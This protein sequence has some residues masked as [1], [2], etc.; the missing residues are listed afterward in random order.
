MAEQIISPGVFTRENDLSFLP[1]GI[2]A[3]GAAIIGP[4]EKGPAFVPTVVRSF[5]EYERRFGPLSAETYVPQ[6][7]R[8]Y[9]KNAGSVTV[10]RVLAGGG[11]T[12]ANGTNE[13]VAI[14]LSGSS[15]NVFLGSIFP[16][17]HNTAV[18]DLSTSTFQNSGSHNIEMGVDEVT[19]TQNFV[20]QLKGATGGTQATVG[21]TYAASINPANYNYIF[22][23]LGDK[24]NNSKTAWNAFGGT[25]GYTYMNFKSLQTSL[26]N[27]GIIDGYSGSFGSGSLVQVST[28]V[29]DAEF[30]GNG[31]GQTEGYSF[32]STPFITSQF[33]N[34]NRT[35]K[36]LF[37]FH[38]LTHGTMCNTDYKISIQNL[39]EP[40]DIDNE[41]QYSTFSVLVRRYS[42]TDKNPVILEQFNNCNL[43]PDSSNY[44]ARVIGDRYPLYNDTLDKVE[45]L[46]DYPNIS[47]YIRVEVDAAVADRATSPKLSPK[48]FAGLINP[49]ATAS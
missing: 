14:A 31:L 32:A 29:A 23:Q 39:R 9:L 27:T 38:T 12:Y 37:K 2:G 7:V 44:I 22:K 35:T 8:E 25:P 30:N 43:D 47:E 24:P 5:A 48:G 17:K 28:Q 40:S 15:G 19:I 3:I 33:L 6:T 34:I 36:Q 26:F 41:E 21:Q 20:I 45:M 4:T 11:Y 16:S 10:C 1:Q 46:G 13:V 18:P 49:I 42:D